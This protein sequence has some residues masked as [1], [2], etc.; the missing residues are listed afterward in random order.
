MSYR[1]ARARVAKLV[2]RGGLKPP[3]PSGGMWVRIP[4]RARKRRR[5]ANQ[6]TMTVPCVKGRDAEKYGK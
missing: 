1:R 3:C 6:W 5:E 2:R 4:P